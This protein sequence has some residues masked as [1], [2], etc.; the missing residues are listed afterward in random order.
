MITLLPVDHDKLFF[1]FVEGQLPRQ[2]Q[3]HKELV[4]I[5]KTRP[6]NIQ[7]FFHGCKNDNFWLNLFDYFHIFAQNIDCGYTL[8]PPH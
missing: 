7:R 4:S 8:E 1:C 3:G 6:C 2:Q 5:T